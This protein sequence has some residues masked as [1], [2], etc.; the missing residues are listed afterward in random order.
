[1]IAAASAHSHPETV[2]RLLAALGERELTV[3][4]RIDHAAGARKVGMELS[5]EQVLVFGSPKAGTA[6]MRDD[7]RIGIQLP[8]RMLVWTDASGAVNVGYEDPRE[9]ADRYDVAAHAAT[10]EAMAGLLA[11]LAQTATSAE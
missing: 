7:P 9:L 11:V 8:L 5:D 4:A 3:F 2:R 6:L 1:M 10:L